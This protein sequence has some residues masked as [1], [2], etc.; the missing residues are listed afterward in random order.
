M[1]KIIDI[2][3]VQSSAIRILVEALKDILTDA[4]LIFDSSGIK[5]IAMDSTHTVLIH[6]KLEASKF[7]MYTCKKKMKIGINMLNLFKLIKTMNNTDT[8][9]LYITEDNT[10]ILGVIINNHDKNTTSNYEL[11]LL[12][13]PEEDIKIPPAEF[14]SELSLPSIDFQKLIRD[15]VNIGK[16][17]E[18]LIE[19]NSARPKFP[20]KGRNPQYWRVNA[21]GEPGKYGPGDMVQVQIEKASGHGLNGT[22]Q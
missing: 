17:V 8:L 20:F 21:K 18:M 15:M 22:I 16:E 19:G 6:M 3:T 10:N 1:N 11:N 5:L 7:E 13:I 2:R 4:N 14:E 9:S 12:D